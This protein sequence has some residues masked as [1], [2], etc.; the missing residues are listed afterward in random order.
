MWNFHNVFSVHFLQ[1]GSHRII[2]KQKQLAYKKTKEEQFFM[3]YIL[4]KHQVILPVMKKMAEYLESNGQG[5][6]IGD[7]DSEKII[8]MNISPNRIYNHSHPVISFLA[9]GC[10]EKI[11]VHTKSF[12]PDGNGQEK[13][14]GEFEISEI[15]K[16]FVEKTILNL[17]K[18]SFCT[19]KIN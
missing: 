14:L 19:T 18:E 16:I 9:V 12:M 5:V 3:K 13:Y 10:T 1:H 6:L 4:A 11:S 8:F 2:D 17:I 7:Y 15:T